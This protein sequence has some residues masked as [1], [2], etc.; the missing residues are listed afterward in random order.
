[1]LSYRD[2]SSFALITL[3]FILVAICDINMNVIRCILSE[4]KA[5]CARD[6]EIYLF[7]HN[8]WI[9]KRDS[10]QILTRLGGKRIKYSKK[11]VER[12]LNNESLF[13]NHEK[14]HVTNT[15]ILYPASTSTSNSTTPAKLP[16]A[17]HFVTFSD[18]KMK[19]TR[20][21]LV[22]QA[23]RSGWFQS[24][25]GY[26]PEDLPPGFKGE[27]HSILNLE[28]GGGYWIWRFPVFELMLDRIPFGHFFVFLDAGF[29]LNREGKPMFI[30]WLNELNASDY[31]E[32]GFQIQES[33]HEYTT[34]RIFDAFQVSKNN[35]EIRNSG[36]I[37]GG[38]LIIRN[39]LHFRKN[40]S[41][42]Y[43]ILASDPY[44]ITDK[45]N[46]EA[47]LLDPDFVDN[48]HDQSIHSLTQKTHGSLVKKWQCDDTVPFRNF[49]L[50][51][52]T[53][54]EVLD[55]E[56]KDIANEKPW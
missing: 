13:Y 41:V 38:V 22:R 47:S 56:Q 7:S 48:R 21:R 14:S 30:Q 11:H 31:D 29:T 18:D 9:S 8:A 19:N 15:S 34:N 52:M 42:I 40:L 32:M 25:V 27:F 12:L 3:I 54:E 5:S 46:E 50:R 33:E 17:V 43:E 10:S 24:A 39:G 16:Y 26:S 36:Q 28:R 20:D 53:D 6:Q 35:T 44:L 45:Y 37:Q 1:M 4:S 51:Y 2:R 49:Y 23:Q 55:W